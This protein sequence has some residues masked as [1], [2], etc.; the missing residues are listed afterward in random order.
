MGA[1]VSTAV[2]VGNYSEECEETVVVSYHRRVRH[3]RRGSST[4]VPAHRRRLPQQVNRRSD[5]VPERDRSS[6][7]I[8]PLRC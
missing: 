6:E 2:Q 3:R 4:S 8:T 5:P 1:M 7:W